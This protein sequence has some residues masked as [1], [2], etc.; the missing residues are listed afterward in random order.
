MKIEKVNAV[1]PYGFQ[2]EVAQA[3]EDKINQLV[4]SYNSL[5]EKLGGELRIE[6]CERHGCS[7]GKFD[8]DCLED[9]G[10]MHEPK[11]TLA[12]RLRK[13]YFSTP[14]DVNAPNADWSELAEYAVE[15]VIEEIEKFYAPRT[16]H[17]SFISE[18]VKSLC[19]KL[20]SLV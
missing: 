4:D 7:L 14:I 19:S 9:H 15:A 6:S 8:C 5:Q 12:E 13:K 10:D 18:D 16:A 11:K 2:L 3:L 20:R 17:N 1:H